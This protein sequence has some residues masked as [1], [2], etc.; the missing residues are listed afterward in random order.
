MVDRLTEKG[1]TQS[2]VVEAFRD[3]AAYPPLWPPV[4]NRPPTLPVPRLGFCFR[5]KPVRGEGRRP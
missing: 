1:H 5:Y 2:D 3:L 4:D